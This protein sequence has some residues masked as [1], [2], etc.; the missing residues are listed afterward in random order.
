MAYTK[1]SDQLACQRKHY[2]AN[3]AAYV[4][5]A[6]A[7]KNK[8]RAQLRAYR[9]TLKCS[10]CPESHPACLDFHHVGEKTISIALAIGAGWSWKRILSEI[11]KCEVLCANC[12]RKLHWP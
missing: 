8:V 12:H 11:A 10:R 3:A 4:Q 9:S 7:R 5:R 1:K 2:R 6:R